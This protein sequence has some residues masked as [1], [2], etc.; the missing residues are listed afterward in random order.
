MKKLNFEQ[1]NN[2]RPA[3]K[4]TDELTTKCDD[5]TGF[6]NCQR[7]TRGVKVSYRYEDYKGQ[8]LKF[9]DSYE[10]CPIKWGYVNSYNVPLGQFSNLF[11]DGKEDV[12]KLF[13][14][15]LKKDSPRGFYISGDNSV[16]KTYT[17]YYMANEM[18]KTGRDVT[19]CTYA[20]MMKVIMDAMNDGGVMYKTKHFT[21]RDTLFIDD[22][23]RGGV[24]D[25][26]VNDIFFDILNTRMLMGL[27]TYFTSNFNTERLKD[28]INGKMQNKTDDYAGATIRARILQLCYLVVID[29]GK[30]YMDDK[31][32]VK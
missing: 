2:K 22:L 5:C 24:S 12:V 14:E 28:V 30:W 7:E 13:K 25:Y 6:E 16:G 9:I 19:I 15:E 3:H 26:K 31:K 11:I 23:G 10:D 4:R 8:K 18:R 1:V 29:D 20:H 17:L 27:P 21:N 32:G